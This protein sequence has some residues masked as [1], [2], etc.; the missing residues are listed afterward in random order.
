MKLMLFTVASRGRKVGDYVLLNED[1]AIR[2]YLAGNAT[3]NTTVTG[4]YPAC[5]TVVSA[6]VP[7][8][9]AFDPMR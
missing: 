9:A 5:T 3:Y 2:E 6:A 4:T 8:V 7:G 1:E